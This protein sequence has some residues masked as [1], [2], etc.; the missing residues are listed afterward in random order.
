MTSTNRLYRSSTDRMISG[1]SGGLA[2]YF[3]VDSSLVRL[4]WI[5]LCFITFGFAALI[6]IVLLVAM[7]REETRVSEPSHPLDDSRV[8]EGSPGP[9]SISRA[10][11]RRSLLALGLVV[12][13]ALLLLTN[14]GWVRWDLLWP[15]VLI[16]LGAAILLGRS[17]RV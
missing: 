2:R 9:R 12:L 5:V 16:G 3:D 15:V 13:G 11:R 17:K 1:V 8:E 4:G 14:F 6:Y 10:S 7:P